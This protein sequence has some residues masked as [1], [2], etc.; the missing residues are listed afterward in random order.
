MKKAFTLIE[1]LVVI[2][3]IGILASVVVVNVG[4][5][6]VK[7]RTAKRISDLKSIATALDLYYDDNGAY[8]DSRDNGPGQWDGIFSCWGDSSGESNPN[9]WIVGLTPKYL[10]Q[11]PRDPTNKTSCNEQYIYRSNGIDYKLLAHNAEDTADV[12]A[13]YPNFWDPS[14][15]GGASDEAGHCNRDGS[16][17]TSWAWGIYTPGA[18]CL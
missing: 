10:S 18:Q 14:R 15:D 7:A 1:L 5:A 17:I 9:G 2:A 4:S 6:R 16:P 3:I 13:K 12:V 11:L 8:P